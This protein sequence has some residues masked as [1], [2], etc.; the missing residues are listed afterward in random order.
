[1]PTFSRPRR[2]GASPDNNAALRPTPEQEAEALMLDNP[3]EEEDFDAS[4]VEGL[5]D[6][7][8]THLGDA[9]RI[10]GRSRTSDLFGEEA[11][12]AAGRATSPKLYAQAAQFPTCTQLRV[13]KWENGIPV[14]LG[15][16]DSTATEEDFVRQFLTAMPRRGEGR[17]QYKLRP[18]DI[19]GQ[20]L[21]QEITSVISEHH[22]SLR[23]AREAEAEEREAAR[24]PFASMPPQQ[25]GTDM[26]G[27]MSRMVEHMLA[28]AEQRSRA[29]EE[30]LEMERERM[31][32]E[33]LRRTQERVDLAT[34][35]A[36]GVQSI[37]ERMMR[38]DQQRQERAMAASTQQSQMLVT[39]LTQIF[40]QQQMMQTQAAEAARR[41][42]EMRMDQ[43][44]QRAVREREAAEEQ[45][46]RDRD[47]FELKR[48]REQE[49]ADYRLRVEREE[50][51]RRLTRE[52]EELDRKDRRE[53]D[54]RDARERWFAEER[55]RRE[56]REARESRERDESRARREQLERD[57]IKTREAE[58]Q[59]QHDLRIE[60]M[61][62]Q[63]LREREHQERMA[64]LAQTNN[65]NDVLG[66]AAKMLGQFG[67]APNE[68]L[69][70]LFGIG[71]KEEG[72]EEGKSSAWMDALPK[73][74]GV[75]SDVARA[76]MQAKA[77]APPP[78]RQQPPMP[79]LPPPYGDFGPMMD[80]MPPRR[81][82]EREPVLVTPPP[83]PDTQ[84][85][86]P[87]EAAPAA[88]PPPNLSEIAAQ[89]GVNLKAQ[90]AARTALRVLI[91]GLKEAPEDKWEE[92][93]S[94]GIANEMTIYHY[95]NAVGVKA[96][97]LENGASPE[98]AQKVI[99]GMQ[100]STLISSLAPDLNYGE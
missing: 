54:E 30:S 72:D 50:A 23:M 49:E 96:A 25:Q 36:Q 59:R 26:G 16:I 99:V 42:D 9:P 52:R 75:V 84:E 10:G 58:R 90:K 73:I 51:E 93:I 24:N 19:R 83:A 1:M 39:T 22:A 33:E 37:T 3:P 63:A 68:I 81:E 79:M 15:T 11:D 14:G 5:N 85:A 64:N 95:A 44:R 92:M 71:G 45:R 89:K 32:S 12:H 41:A 13:W 76:S 55:N 2:R 65:N 18:I 67:I 6:P 78:P 53:K 74:I 4:E 57:D 21:G 66:N 100:T 7:D 77:S 8:V 38:D 88:P 46:R 31:R 98:L 61:K 80:A 34:Q 40:S 47:E 82:R 20:E 97:M 94:M 43:E 62:Q 60:E 87:E 29:L 35:A 28:T 91:K 48:K 70:R 17:A 86:P 56:E 27:E 69:P